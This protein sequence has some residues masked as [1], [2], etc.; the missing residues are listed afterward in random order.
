MLRRTF[1]MML[2][3]MLLFMAFGFQLVR[4]QSESNQAVEKVRNKVQKIGTGVNA[5]V[6]VKLQDNSQYKGY[7]SS[8]DHDGF[9]VV[10]SK[11]G[12]SKTASYADTTSV[13]KVGSG[14]STK[15]LII[16]G[17]AAVGVAVTWVIVKPVL[18]DGGAQ[19]RGPC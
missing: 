11:T 1:A 19:T 13:K 2:S 17:A 3:G 8:A 6:E 5:R 18:C 7:I 9:T 16:I 15:T 12:S 10:E 14:L 4:A